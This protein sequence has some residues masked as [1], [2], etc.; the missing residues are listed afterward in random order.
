[1]SGHPYQGTCWQGHTFTLWELFSFFFFVF[2]AHTKS[3]K[4]Q[5]KQ[6]SSSQKFLWHFVGWFWLVT[7]FRFFVRAKSCTSHKAFLRNKKWSGTKSSFSVSFF[8]GSFE[9]KCFFYFILLTDQTSLSGCFYF[10]MHWA[11]YAF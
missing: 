9:E 11:I 7:C 2:V 10:V 8:C 3:T 5:N 4:T 6:F 1:M